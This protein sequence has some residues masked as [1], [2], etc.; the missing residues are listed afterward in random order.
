MQ[1]L[2]T[3]NIMLTASMLA[4]FRRDMCGTQNMQLCQGTLSAPDAAEH[5]LPQ[6][7]IQ[8][9]MRQLPRRPVEYNPTT[10]NKACLKK[11]VATV[12]KQD[13]QWCVSGDSYL[14]KLGEVRVCDVCEPY[15]RFPVLAPL[16]IALLV[17]QETLQLLLNFPIQLLQVEL[18]LTLIKFEKLLLCFGAACLLAK[19][20]EA[21]S[22]RPFQNSPAIYNLAPSI[23]DK[24][25]LASRRGCDL[26]QHLQLVRG[27]FVKCLQRLH[28][29]KPA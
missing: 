14:D 9:S 8:S 25:E 10:V 29:N 23:K 28:S 6:I 11:P 12:A 15:E 19:A 27:N 2:Q 5:G 4:E 1:A 7:Q 22:I 18:C 13:R 24:L 20:V 17:L 16:N 21:K 3:Q 26:T